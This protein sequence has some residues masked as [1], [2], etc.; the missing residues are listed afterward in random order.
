MGMLR[1]GGHVRLGKS[2]AG[3][4]EP[5]LPLRPWKDTH[6]KH[7]CHAPRKP[8]MSPLI[9]QLASVS[10]CLSVWILIPQHTVE[11]S[12]GEMTLQQVRVL[13]LS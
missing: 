4:L 8:H 11:I 2:S 1:A 3:I 10:E 12:L 7:L 6:G 5:T 13:T 9:G